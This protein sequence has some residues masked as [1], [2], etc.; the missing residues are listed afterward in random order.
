MI[1]IVLA[2]K[3]HPLLRAIGVNE[4]PNLD[5]YHA[6]FDRQMLRDPEGWPAAIE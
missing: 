2:R 3:R 4:K 1:I 5:G 6:E